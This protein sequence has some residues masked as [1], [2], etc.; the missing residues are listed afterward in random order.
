MLAEADIRAALP[1]LWKYAF[2]LTSRVVNAEGLLQDTLARAWAKRA[3]YHGGHARAWLFTL[4]HNVHVSK[5]R[6]VSAQPLAVNTYPLA[7][8]SSLA[9]AAAFFRLVVRDVVPELQIMPEGMRRAVMLAA[10]STDNYA[11]MAAR[12]KITLGRSNLGCL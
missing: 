3:C 12:L 2:K 1:A 4:M 11:G 7:K 9:D 5:I 6:R 10:M 8:G